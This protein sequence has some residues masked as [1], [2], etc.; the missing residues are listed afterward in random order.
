MLA[1]EQAARTEIEE[2]ISTQ[3]CSKFTQ[4]MALITATI[5]FLIFYYF[6]MRPVL[7]QFLSPIVYVCCLHV[8][9]HGWG[10][11]G[12]GGGGLKLGKY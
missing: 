11:G 9:V 2:D 6:L 8:C 5:V 1:M 3:T 4:N 7:L 12:G 10:G